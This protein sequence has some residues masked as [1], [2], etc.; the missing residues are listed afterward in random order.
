MTRES[1]PKLR[2]GGNGAEHEVLVRVDSVDKDVLQRRMAEERNG[3]KGEP[4]D[5]EEEGARDRQVDVNLDVEVQM[6]K[7]APVETQ[8][9][10]YDPTSINRETDDQEPQHRCSARAMEE[11]LQARSGCRDVDL[12]MSE[13]KKVVSCHCGQDVWLGGR[14]VEIDRQSRQTGHIG[15]E[16]KKRVLSMLIHVDL[17][18]LEAIP[19]IGAEEVVARGLER[20]SERA[21]EG[22]SAWSCQHCLPEE[23]L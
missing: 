12:E 13:M 4:A 14:A 23:I 2:H 11:A 19:S 10:C 8:E 6:E 20:S 21:D 3:L 9:Q 15:K 7:I 16:A 1:R 5:A 17:Q 22:C 18:L